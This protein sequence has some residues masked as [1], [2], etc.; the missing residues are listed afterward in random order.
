MEGEGFSSPI[1]LAHQY[2]LYIIVYQEF[3]NLRLKLH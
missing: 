2:Y 3:I 1:H